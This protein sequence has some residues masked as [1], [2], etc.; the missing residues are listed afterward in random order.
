MEENSVVNSGAP[1][2]AGMEDYSAGFNE[3]EAYAA[4]E[5]SGVDAP[6]EAQ[7][8]TEPNSMQAAMGKEL[9]RIRQSERAKYEK[10]L[11]SD[12]AR[13]VG[14]RL[15]DG[16]MRL[17]NVDAETAAKLVETNYQNAIE[18]LNKAGIKPAANAK[19]PGKYSETPED[20]AKRIRQDIG[21][22]KLPNG[23]DFDESIDDMDF[24]KLLTEMPPAAAV[25]VYR[26]EQQAKSAPRDLAEKLRAREQLPKPF[27]PSQQATPEL[28]YFAMSDE[29]FFELERKIND[30]KNRGIRFKT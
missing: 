4:V 6:D 29:A 24:V 27:K 10:Q 5:K 11:N 16:I 13:S 3:A 19:T 18:R 20:M 25:R 1:V 22:I 8:D 23:F 26:A 7:A 2:G 17:H 12:P 9:Q 21:K 15:I 14:Q 28:D 30:A